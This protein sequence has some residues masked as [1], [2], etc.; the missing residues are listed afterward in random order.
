[1]FVL[2]VL[3]L[4]RVFFFFLEFLTALKIIQSCLQSLPNIK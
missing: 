3:S 1:M 4:L 2:N